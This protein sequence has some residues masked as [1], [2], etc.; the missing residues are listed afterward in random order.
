M[1]TPYFE[2]EG[3][4]LFHGDSREIVPMLEAATIDLILTDPPYGVS[5]SGVV[6]N[7]RPGRGRRSFDFF[8]NDSSAESCDLACRVLRLA[9][10]LLKPDASGYAW[11]GHRQF[12]ELTID[13]EGRG[14]TTRFLVWSKSCPAPPPPGSGWPS[15]AELCLYW[16]RPG[17]RWNHTG[18]RPP[19]GNVIAADSY[20]HGKPGKVS[21]PTQ[22]PFECVTP[23]IAASSLP[24][25]T[26][27]DP[28]AGSG[29]TLV[30]AKQAGCKAIGVEREERYCEIICKRLEQGVF[31]W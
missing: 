9:E 16:F 17:R 14:W 31:S 12:S 7:G 20:R 27:L 26:I 25:D 10:S 18:D 8:P 13:L 6:H 24:G 2:S 28:F 4:R 23:L 11:C 5:Q 21:H 1:L 3:V 29:T 15:A 22:K 19:P 30:A